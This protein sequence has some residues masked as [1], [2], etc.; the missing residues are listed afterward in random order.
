MMSARAFPNRTG[1]QHNFNI[2]RFLKYLLK[3]GLRCLLSHDHTTNFPLFW[4]ALAKKH[5]VP[6]VLLQVGGITLHTSRPKIL[7]G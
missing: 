2:E 1:F 7:P 5:Q 4:Q 6:T 3:K